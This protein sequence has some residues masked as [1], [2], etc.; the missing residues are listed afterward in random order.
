MLNAPLKYIVTCFR[1]IKPNLTG[2]IAV[3]HSVEEDTYFLAFIQ[4][5][6]DRK[7]HPLAFEARNLTKIELKYGTMMIL[8]NIV[9]WEVR[10]IRCYTTLIAEFR[11][12]FAKSS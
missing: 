3:Y 11:A 7:K 6:S 5:G 8:A 2:K 10:K 1:L 12:V 9:A 4:T